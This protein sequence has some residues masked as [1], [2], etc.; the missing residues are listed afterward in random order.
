MSSY[1]SH[2]SVSLYASSHRLHVV[3]FRVWQPWRH[4]TVRVRETAAAGHTASSPALAADLPHTPRA[5]SSSALTIP[6]D[7]W[8]VTIILTCSYLTPMRK[9]PDYACKQ[10]ADAGP[11]PRPRPN[12]ESLESAGQCQSPTRATVPGLNPLSF[13]LEPQYSCPLRKRSLIGLQAKL[14]VHSSAHE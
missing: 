4:G 14:Q 11:L 5:S 9:E 1:W 6:Q 2:H 13:I 8:E 7:A 12:S 10:H 3:I